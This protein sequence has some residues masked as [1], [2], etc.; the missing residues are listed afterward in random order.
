MSDSEALSEGNGSEF[1]DIGPGAT[2]V[3]EGMQLCVRCCFRYKHLSLCPEQSSYNVSIG[4]QLVAA[5][6][7]F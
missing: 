2:N 6:G 1:E 7:E 5:H 3:G 4:K